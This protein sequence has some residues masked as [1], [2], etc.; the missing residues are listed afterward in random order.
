MTMTQVYM[1]LARI[2]FYSDLHGTRL[3]LALAEFVWGVTLMM[4]GDTF[5]RPTYTVMAATMSET[6]WALVFLV[7]SLMQLSILI[8][9]DY[10]SRFATYFAAWNTSMWAYV[11]VSMY[12]SV[13]PPTGGHFRRTRAGRRRWVDMDSFRLKNQRDKSYGLWTIALRRMRSCTQAPA[14]S[15]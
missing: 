14:L 4:P 11:V 2:A 10:H 13:S 5:G 9:A 7:T 6:A 12:M 8:K 1:R 15:S 3:M